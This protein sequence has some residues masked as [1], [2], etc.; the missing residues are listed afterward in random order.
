MTVARRPNALRTLHRVQVPNLS[1]STLNVLLLASEFNAV[2]A[3][4]SV[5]DSKGK[6]SSTALFDDL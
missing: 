6:L 2:V 4:N 1:N 3:A 5:D